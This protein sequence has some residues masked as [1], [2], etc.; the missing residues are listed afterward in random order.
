MRVLCI[1][2]GC[3]GHL[4]AKAA[5][6]RIPGPVDNFAVR[7]K[8]SSIESL[9]NGKLFDAIKNREYELRFCEPCESHY[10]KDGKYYSLLNDS[11]KILHNNPLTEKYNI[12]IN[13]RINNFKENYLKDDIY[14][15]YTIST[16]FTTQKKTNNRFY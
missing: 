9:F 1:G 4:I 7:D 8:F 16:Y 6:I 14:Y 15:F 5:G 2:C 11:Y 10:F 12:E 13:K 3:E